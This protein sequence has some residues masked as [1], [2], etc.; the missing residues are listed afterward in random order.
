MYMY[1]TEHISCLVTVVNITWTP[2]AMRFGLS[3]SFRYLY[4]HNKLQFQCQ[5]MHKSYNMHRGVFYSMISVM[6][7]VPT[8]LCPSLS[9]N[10]CFTSRGMSCLSVSI[11]GVSSPGITISL[12]RGRGVGEGRRG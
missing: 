5:Q 10:L 7:P 12:S 1:S 3:K 4:I 9:V 2:G 6:T 8:V 11:R